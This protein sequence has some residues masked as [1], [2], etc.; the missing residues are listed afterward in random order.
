MAQSATLREQYW[1]PNLKFQIS[2]LKL[3]RSEKGYYMGEFHLKS[4][5]TGTQY[6]WSTHESANRECPPRPTSSVPN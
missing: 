5:V 1:L 3:F 4:V 6:R 2:N